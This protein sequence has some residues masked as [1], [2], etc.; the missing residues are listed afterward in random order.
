M[1]LTW[2]EIKLNNLNESVTISTGCP[3]K[4]GAAEK[5]REHPKYASSRLQI[6]TISRTSYDADF[7]RKL[8]Q[9][10]HR[11]QNGNL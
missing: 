3:K 7:D 2:N 9:S 4:K 6:Y 10:E 1:S 5:L 11:L 8:L